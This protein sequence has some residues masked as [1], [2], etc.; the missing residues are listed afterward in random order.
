[1]RQ[2]EAVGKP[3]PVVLQIRL[4]TGVARQCEQLGFVNCSGNENRFRWRGG[5][6]VA[7]GTN[8]SN[9]RSHGSEEEQEQTG[10]DHAQGF[11]GWR[12]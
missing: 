10:S 1:V 4:G 12:S 6:Q 3:A 8:L 9:D 7:F 5:R 2:R 11:H